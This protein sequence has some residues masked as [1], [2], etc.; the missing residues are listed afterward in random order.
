MDEYLTKSEHT[1]YIGYWVSDKGI[2]KGIKHRVKRC[3]K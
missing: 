2:H 3:A 1:Y